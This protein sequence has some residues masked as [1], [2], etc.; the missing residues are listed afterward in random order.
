[1]SENITVTKEFLQEQPK[2]TSCGH[3]ENN[4]YEERNEKDTFKSNSTLNS[5]DVVIHAYVWHSPNTGF[6]GPG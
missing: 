5:T 2:T 1:V 4:L 3:S 6:C